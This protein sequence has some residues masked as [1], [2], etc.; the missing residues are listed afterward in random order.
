MPRKLAVN[1]AKSRQ[2]SEAEQRWLRDSSKVKSS[3]Y[4]VERPKIH[5]G[6]L[7]PTNHEGTVHA[8]PCNYFQSEVVDMQQQIICQQQQ[9]QQQQHNKEPTIAP[10]ELESNLTTSSQLGNSNGVT[11]LGNSSCV[12]AAMDGGPRFGLVLP[13]V[14][15]GVHRSTNFKTGIVCR[16]VSNNL[17]KRLQLIERDI[18]SFSATD[19]WQHDNK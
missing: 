7:F 18:I 12:A 6:N 16:C 11:S 17:F 14:V 2:Q 15:S 1:R 4:F 13:T 10:L 5:I 19:V 9:Q 8:S 3:R